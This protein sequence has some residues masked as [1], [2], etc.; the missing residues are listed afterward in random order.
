VHILPKTL[1]HK[2]EQ[3]KGRIAERFD[4]LLHLAM[5]RRW[6]TIFLTALLFGVSLFL[7]KF[8][9]HQFFPSSDRPELLVDLN[10]PQNSSIHETRAVMD[11]LETTLKDD[12]DIDHWSA[13]VGEGAIR[14]YLPLD[15]QLQNNFY[16]QLVIVTKDLEA[17]ER[18][19]AR[20]RDRLR[21]DYVGISTY[22][23]PL[24]MGPPVGRPIQYRVSGPQID[25][26]REYAMGLAGVLDGNPNIGD[27]VYD[28]NEPGKMLKIDIAQD[29]ARQLGLSSEDV[30][31][32]M[33]SVVT[34][35]AV[36]QVRDDIYL[37]NVIG[38]AEDSERGSLET[39]ESLQIVTP[40]GTSIPLKAFAKVSYELEQPLVWRR[41]RKPTITVKA[42]LRGEIQPTDLVARLAPEVKRF[43]DGLP[44][45]Y[46]IEVGG[47]VE[48]AAKGQ[49]SVNAGV[50]LFIVVVLSLLMVQ[51]RS[52]SRM[53][54]VFLTAPLGLIGVTLFLL[55]FRQPFGFVAMLGTIA[56]AGM[57]MRN[58]VILVDQIEQD[59]SHGLD[60]WHAI[61]EAT[62]RR[63]RPIVLTALAAVLAMIPLSRSV[64]FGP[65]AVAI[66]GGLIVATV[67]TLLFLPA[68]YAAWFRVKKDEARA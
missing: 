7:M 18:V 61:I 6:T 47:T 67:L 40:S 27:I 1:K 15:Q 54:M 5:R 8:V 20:L 51:L 48:D 13:Y 3:K 57:I 58:S 30:A 28:W 50:P 43:A 53:A 11:R 23:Q 17:R 60:R 36:T 41:D 68:L 22:V 10:L 34:G 38:R 39:L 59:I 66:M 19:A 24:E 26:V 12:E 55:L 45:N 21:K 9:Q 65:M 16:G 37:V 62:V 52:F 63:F 49:S 35:S 29:K 31:Q 25:K 46:R 32:I 44:A 33:N 2:S 56:L 64:F 42:S 4:S 14:F